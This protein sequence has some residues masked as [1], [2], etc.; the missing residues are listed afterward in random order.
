MAAVLKL[1]KVYLPIGI[2]KYGDGGLAKVQCIPH[3][4]STGYCVLTVYIS[5]YTKKLLHPFRAIY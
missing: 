3:V 1:Q 5:T 4:Y 2:G